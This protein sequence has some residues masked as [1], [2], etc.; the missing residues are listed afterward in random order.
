MYAVVLEDI[1]LKV[2]QVYCRKSL[3]NPSLDPYRDIIASLF[4][5]KASLRKQDVKAGLA[6][7]M[8]E[9]IS[10]VAYTKIMR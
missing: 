9:D 2:G 7:S 8:A 3:N 5:S 1:S 6:S 10:D 4:A